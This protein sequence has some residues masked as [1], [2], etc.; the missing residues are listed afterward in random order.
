MRC[1]A[2]TIAATS[3][4][5]PDAPS[6]PKGPARM[7]DLPAIQYRFRPM[8]LRDAMIFSRWRYPAE[9]AIYD[10]D[11]AALV[12]YALLRAPIQR[13]GVYPLAVDAPG[14]ACVSI[15][16]LV[17][18]GEDVEIGVGMRPDLMGHGMGLAL[19]L[20]GMEYARKRLHPATFSLDVATFN[21]RAITVYERA[22][23]QP[24][25]IKPT[26]ARGK[27]IDSMKMTR[28]A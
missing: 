24:G 17:K 27:R 19:M 7:P 21:H 10:L 20:Q 8:R 13:L 2:R 25:P 14:D 15:F 22:G 16:S 12:F 1:G 9:Y 28:P 4:R 5:P 6:A 3:S 23:F 26:F 11:L 18:R